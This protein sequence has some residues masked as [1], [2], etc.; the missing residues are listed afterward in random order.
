MQRNFL[1]F[2]VSAALVVGACAGGGATTAPSTA[3]PT[4][5]ATVA[6]ATPGATT[7]G[8][9]TPEA[10]TGG[11]ATPE[12]TTGG[13]ATPEATTGG[14]EATPAASAG[15]GIVID[16]EAVTGEVRL[17]G[18]QSS[19]A[20]EE[21]LSETVDAFR[22]KYPNI[23][24]NYESIPTDY[25]SNMIGQ[26]SAHEPPDVF[27]V[28]AENAAAWMEDGV[29]EPLDPYITGNSFDTSTFYPSLLSVFQ[30]DGV[31]YGL[32]K[33]AGPLALFYNT[34]MLTEANVQP[35]TTWDELTAAAAAL[36]T[37][38]HAG[39]CISP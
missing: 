2:M 9:A 38:E 33:D 31:T 37:D 18:W 36:T 4:T 27:Y 30:K 5:A 35:P 10:T 15:E 8:E 1:I 39:L 34:D 28:Q 22:A 3:G 13:E 26:F 6:G 20:E 16:P 17:T 21:L 24:V 25:T 32:P 12:A 23:T 11:E 19:P 29:L 14:G 7:G